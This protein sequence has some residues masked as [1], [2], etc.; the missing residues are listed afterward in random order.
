[1]L[2]LGLLWIVGDGQKIDA[3]REP[4]VGHNDC[5]VI[6]SN[7]GD[8]LINIKVRNL[9]LDDFTGWNETLVST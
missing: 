5:S 1:M 3:W 7:R 9:I 8:W 2:E 4:W 6:A